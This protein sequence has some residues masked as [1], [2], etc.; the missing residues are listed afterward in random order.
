MSLLVD[1][2]MSRRVVRVAIAYLLTALGLLLSVSV[3]D[4]WLLLPDWTMRMVGGTA[5]VILPFILMLI[6]ALEDRGPDNLGKLP[7]RR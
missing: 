3:V 7:R 6:W 1:D 5:F 2:L 4:A